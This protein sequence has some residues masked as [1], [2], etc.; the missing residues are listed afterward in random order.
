MS[1]ECHVRG[2]V[3]SVY[4]HGEVCGIHFRFIQTIGSTLLKTVKMEGTARL[5]DAE[6][7][8]YK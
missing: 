8:Y 3:E 2:E 5:K 1:C 7:N 6:L 4:S